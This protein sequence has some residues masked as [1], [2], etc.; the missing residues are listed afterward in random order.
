MTSFEHA[1][2]ARRRARSHGLSRLRRRRER[3]LV[4]LGSTATRR[5]PR[6]ARHLER[7]RGL[8][9]HERRTRAH[10][11]LQLL[12]HRRPERVR[13]ARHRRLRSQ[14]RADDHRRTHLR[15]RPGQQLRDALDRVN[16]RRSCAPTRAGQG[17]V[18]ALGWFCTK[19]S[20]GVY[21]ATPAARGLSLDRSARRRRSRSRACAS[22]QRDGAATVES[23]TVTHASNGEP[24]RLIIAARTPDG[25][26][27]WCHSTDA[28]LMARGR[29]R[30]NSSDAPARLRTTSSRSELVEI[31][32]A[33]GLSGRLDARR[34]HEIDRDMRKQQPNRRD[35]RADQLEP[36]SR[37]SS[38]SRLTELNGRKMISQ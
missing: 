4:D 23:Y 16:G 33:A 14:S 37:S 2:V 6:D 5:L 22:D 31:D 28:S 8:R 20:W 17:L 38:K 29:E 12:S 13:R 36:Q 26:R 34:S 7:P 10:R 35:R 1:T 30:R 27:T 24:E 32:Q 25:V 11:S 18:T 3:S 21:S 19:H 9:R 15:R